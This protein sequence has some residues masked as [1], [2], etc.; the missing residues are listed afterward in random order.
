MEF[1]Q[2][3]ILFKTMTVSLTVYDSTS[4]RYSIT[5]EGRSTQHALIADADEFSD[6]IIRHDVDK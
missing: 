2:E 5:H 6:L 3:L 4:S 1:L